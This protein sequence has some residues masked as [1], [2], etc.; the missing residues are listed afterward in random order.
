MKRLFSIVLL[1]CIVL[2]TGCAN[3]SGFKSVKEVGQLPES[4]EKIVADNIFHDVTAFEQRVLKT[5]IIDKNK[6]NRTVS[7]RVR[8]MDLYGN[9]VVEYTCN[10]DDAYHVTTLTATQDGGFLFVLGFRDYAYGQKQWA[11]DNGFSSR[12]IKCDQFGNLQ[13]DT[14]LN[15]IEGYALQYCFEKNEKF[16]FFGEKET[17]ETKTTGVVSPTDIYMV[18][19]DKNGNLLKNK[20]I[21]GTDYDSLDAAEISGEAF[22]LSINSQS[23]DGDFSNSNSK[24][25]G[26]DW[27]ITVNDELEIIEKKKETGRDVFNEKI[28]E[29]DG[30]PVYKE[31]GFL[32][33]YDA[34]EPNVFID[35]G[36]FYLIVSE[37][38]TGIYED[39]PMMISS[40]WYYTETVYSGY[41]DNGK[42]LFRVAIDSS[43]D[44][45]NWREDLS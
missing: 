13:F 44:Y 34:G 19:L 27:V 4:F 37:N 32:K 25:Y 41:D 31:D 8:M 30:V 6:E 43:P 21:A 20:V 10:A 45:D 2:L 38:I 17:L 1:S 15:E 35:Y 11:S 40:T 36:D 3:N 29:K 12:V 42:L 39:T 33:N 5:E 26:V 24:G 28:G 16:Y 18:I 23:D 14:P 7:Y 9:D 22:L